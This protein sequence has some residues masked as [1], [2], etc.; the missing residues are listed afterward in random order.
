MREL[1]IL[2]SGP[3]VTAI[4]EGRK[5]Q[6]R[7]VIRKVGD[8][9]RLAQP[10]F[11]VPGM[12]VYFTVDGRKRL[13]VPCSFGSPGDRLWIRETYAR[14]ADVRTAD[15]GST[16]LTQNAFYR[17]DYPTGL[18]HDDGSEVKWR[19]CIH[20]PRVFS[21][22]VLEVKAVRAERLQSITAD[23]ILSEGI[24]TP[25]TTRN[26]PQGKGVPLIRA[27][28][29]YAPVKYLEIGVATADQIARAEFA[30]AWDALNHK[31]GF[32]WE[33]NPWVFVVTFERRNVLGADKQV[34]ATSREKEGLNACQ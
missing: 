25:V 24:R 18:H 23:E 22:I 21:R 2:F 5:T 28:G 15:P 20:M 34:L 8:E 31:R 17:A 30:S 12:A 26:C 19:P 11:Q 3:M 1:P 4:L 14:L 32:G 29:K 9:W 27:S 6:T 33:T 16:A 13:A 7:R 10:E